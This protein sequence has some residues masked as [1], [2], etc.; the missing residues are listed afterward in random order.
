[1]LSKRAGRASA[2]RFSVAGDLELAILLFM[3]NEKTLIS[4]LADRSSRMVERVPAEFVRAKTQS[5]LISKISAIL[6]FTVLRRIAAKTASYALRTSARPT[7]EGC[8]AALRAPG[9]P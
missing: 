5:G 2:K 9:R 1:L 6:N 4:L 3:E 7:A 8:T